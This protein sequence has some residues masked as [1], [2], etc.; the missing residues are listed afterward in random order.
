MYMT[1]D[2]GDIETIESAE[3]I[4]DNQDIRKIGNLYIRF[5]CSG[6]YRKTLYTE[7][8][9][10]KQALELLYKYMNAGVQLIRK[11]DLIK[12]NAALL[13]TINKLRRV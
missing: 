12:E 9:R 1:F 13:P 5:A 10:G 3:I 8:E 7:I 11:Q 2:T 6:R 4:T